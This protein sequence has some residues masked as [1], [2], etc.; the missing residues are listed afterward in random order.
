LAFSIQLEGE[1]NF[2]EILSDPLPIIVEALKKYK[3][4]NDLWD[5]LPDLEIL[6]AQC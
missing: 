6:K 1:I 3:I 4:K 2:P 5:N